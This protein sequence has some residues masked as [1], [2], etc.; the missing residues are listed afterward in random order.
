MVE[1]IAFSFLGAVVQEVAHWHELRKKFT[2]TRVR[3]LFRSREY[4][5]VTIAMIILTPVCCWVLLDG[6]DSNRQVKFFSGAALPLLLKKTVAAVSNFDT[7]RLGD[8][9]VSD[10]FQLHS[11]GR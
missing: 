11:F 7:I 6:L 3:T 8:S 2:D 9:P 1:L 10:Y 5:L 4:W